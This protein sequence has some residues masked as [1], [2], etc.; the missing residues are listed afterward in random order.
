MPAHVP[1]PR[2]PLLK[3]LA[4][5]RAGPGRDSDA[6][7]EAMTAEARAWLSGLTP[8]PRGVPLKGPPPARNGR[9]ALVLRPPCR[10]AGRGAAR[11]GDVDRFDAAGG[12]GKRFEFENE[13]D[14]PLLG[15]PD[16]TPAPLR[17]WRKGDGSRMM[18]SPSVCWRVKVAPPPREVGR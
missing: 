3:G 13:K 4:A 15:K 8:L 14:E 12:S 17:G 9:L 11:K 1:L 2:P 5:C 16:R 18:W 7:E 10:E 6:A